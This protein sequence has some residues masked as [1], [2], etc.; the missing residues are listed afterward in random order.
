MIVGSSETEKKTQI[1]IRLIASHSLTMVG[2]GGPS[3]FRGND[4]EVELSPT[5]E[6]KKLSFQY[7]CHSIG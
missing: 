5:E 4:E 7:S 2:E 3:D 1:E 6:W